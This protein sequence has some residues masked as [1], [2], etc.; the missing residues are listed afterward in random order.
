MEPGILPRAQPDNHTPQL[1]TTLPSATYY[2]SMVTSVSTVPLLVRSPKPDLGELPFGRPFTLIFLNL[3]ANESLLSA[4]EDNTADLFGVLADI[5]SILP[6]NG[7]LVIALPDVSS[8]VYRLERECNHRR[9]RSDPAE[10]PLSVYRD[11]CLQRCTLKFRC[12]ACGSCG[13]AT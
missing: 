9:R 10:R 4:D 11:R 13:T 5:G 1:C 2:R 12:A 7:T 8:D 3:A 6:E